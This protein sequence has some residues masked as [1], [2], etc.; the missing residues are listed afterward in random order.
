[1]QPKF[2]YHGLW[3]ALMSGGELTE[4][5]CARCRKVLRVYSVIG[6]TLLGLCVLAIVGITVWT[7]WSN[8]P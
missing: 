6:L 3:S 5:F 2:M 4:Y 7:R 8:S 1:M